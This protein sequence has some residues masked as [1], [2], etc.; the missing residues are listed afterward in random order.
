MEIPIGRRITEFRKPAAVDSHRD[1]AILDLHEEDL[2]KIEFHA[3]L[4]YMVGVDVAGTG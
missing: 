4:Q 3:V 1:L 2:W